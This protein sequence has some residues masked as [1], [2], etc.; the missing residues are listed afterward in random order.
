MPDDPEG[1]PGACRASG[2]GRRLAHG[3]QVRVT[4][5]EQAGD[6]GVHA[7]GEALVAVAGPDLLADGGQHGE[8][9]GWQ[10]SQECQQLAAGLGVLESGAVAEREAGSVVVEEPIGQDGLAGLAGRPGAG[11][12]GMP[13]RGRASAV[14]SGPGS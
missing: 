6:D 10:G 1:R 5:V 8:A 12:R 4:G 9:V 14:R 2:P 11:A 7:G 13:R 3:S